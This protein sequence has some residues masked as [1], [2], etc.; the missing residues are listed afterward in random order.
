RGQSTSNAL[1]GADGAGVIAAEHERYPATG[2]QLFGAARQ[3]LPDGGNDLRGVAGGRRSY[4][5]APCRIHTRLAQPRDEPVP[6]Q[7]RGPGGAAG[8]GSAGTGGGAKDANCS[9]QSRTERLASFDV[10]R[11]CRGVSRSSHFATRKARMKE[12]YGTKWRRV[13][14]S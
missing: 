12:D 2:D 5:G 7:S 13:E 9:T 4:G 11:C 10:L 8:I 14:R 6:T 3:C 1:P